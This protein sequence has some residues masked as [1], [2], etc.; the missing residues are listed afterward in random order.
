MHKQIC[1][2]SGCLEYFIFLKGSAENATFSSAANREWP[3]LVLLLPIDQCKAEWQ[4]A[5]MAAPS[6]REGRSALNFQ[7]ARGSKTAIL[8]ALV[9]A[10][11]IGVAA[12][13]WHC[14][15]ILTLLPQLCFA[16]S[17]RNTKGS[18]L[19]RRGGNWPQGRVLEAHRVGPTL[20]WDWLQS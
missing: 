18:E 10:R 12:L 19:H 9:A 7:R 14:N 13:L 20:L 1:R 2:V 16:A 11:I 5:R 15:C 6:C 3:S 4:Q 8:L 17:T